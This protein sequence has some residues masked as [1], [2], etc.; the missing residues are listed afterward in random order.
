MIGGQN[1]SNYYNDIYEMNNCIK[2][3]KNEVDSDIVMNP[4]NLITEFN[5]L[6]CDG[7]K[8]LD[9]KID[10]LVIIDKSVTEGEFKL[11][12][13]KKPLISKKKT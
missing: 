10:D 11:N 2:F 9:Y 12:E 4:N 8:I 5:I 6:T 7:D 1:E 3:E 13:H